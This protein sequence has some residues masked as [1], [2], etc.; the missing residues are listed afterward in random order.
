MHSHKIALLVGV[1]V[2][3]LTPLANAHDFG[4]TP[5]ADEIALWDIDVRPDGTGLPLGSGTVLRGKQVYAD[6]CE[7]CHGPNGQGGIKDRLAGGQ[8]SLASDKPI[9][10]V[11]SYWPYAPTLFDYIRRAMPYPAPG[12]LDTD[13]TYSVAAYI[14]NLNGLL[15]D[16][17]K[18]DQES[19]P[20]IK[21]PNRDGFVPDPVFKIDNEPAISC[22]CGLTP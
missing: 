2:G 20:K 19:M 12:S 4:R 1:T 16:D 14:L 5:T 9:K 7:A 6:N 15:P 10:T 11:G 17:G 18:L 21:M 3:F 13:D 22:K 8:G